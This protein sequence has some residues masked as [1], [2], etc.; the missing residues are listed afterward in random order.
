MCWMAAIPWIMGIGAV[1]SVAS[2]LNKPSIPDPPPTPKLAPVAADP[3]PQ[4]ATPRDNSIAVDS[5]VALRNKARGMSSW[6]S[7]NQTGGIGLAGTTAP[8][9]KTLLGGAPMSVGA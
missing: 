8:N 2:A 4:A 9:K 1:A 5:K 3:T 6:L 7:T